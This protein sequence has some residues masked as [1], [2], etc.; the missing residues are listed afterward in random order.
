MQLGK[1]RFFTE[2]DADVS[3]PDTKNNSDVHF[4][5]VSYSVDIVKLLLGKRTSVKFTNKDDENP[6]HI[7][8]KSGNLGARKSFCFYKEML[9]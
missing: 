2:K 7:S 4:A 6:Q 8:A 1:L 9:F 5:A 3:V